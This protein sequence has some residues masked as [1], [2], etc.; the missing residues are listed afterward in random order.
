ML[1]ADQTAF[2]WRSGRGSGDLLPA[3]VDLLGVRLVPWTERDVVE[4]VFDIDARPHRGGWIITANVDILRQITRDPALRQLVTR[5]TITVA[6]GMPLVWA[7][8]IQ[9]TPLPERITG[10]ALLP[11]L[12]ARAAERG[13]SVYLLGGHAGVADAAASRLR[14]CHPGLRVA[15]WSPPFGI[16]STAEGLDQIRR[17]ILA[18]RP[19]IVF[20][21]F[22]FPKQEQVI[23]RLL[24]SAPEAWFIGCGAALDFTAGRVLRAPVWMQRAGLEWMHRLLKDPR[25]LFRRYIVNDIPFAVK[26]MLQSVLR[27]YNPVR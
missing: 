27:R 1:T 4:H 14:T 22:G 2:T 19:D 20:C 21:G 24:D 7:S 9:R 10:A 12:S 18:N 13:S 23:S 15:G 17:R 16:E 5:A 11:S 26:L 6:D 25:R 8:R 3:Q